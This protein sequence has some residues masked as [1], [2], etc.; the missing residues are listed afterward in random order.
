MGRTE[1]RQE[2][3]QVP[4][5]AQLLAEGPWFVNEPCGAPPRRRKPPACG[6]SYDDIAG[7]M[8]R[9]EGRPHCRTSHRYPSWRQEEEQVSG[10]SVQVVVAHLLRFGRQLRR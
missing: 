6:S 5:E 1:G 8:P 4:R 7:S 3:P 9:E 2:F 10:P